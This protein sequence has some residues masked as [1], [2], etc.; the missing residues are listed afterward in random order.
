[1]TQ[2]NLSSQRSSMTPLHGGVPT[3]PFHHP[4]YILFEVPISLTT[5]THTTCR[6]TKH[7]AHSLT[8]SGNNKGYTKLV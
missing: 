8:I 5:T 4:H 2:F 6:H 3:P 7:T 1:M